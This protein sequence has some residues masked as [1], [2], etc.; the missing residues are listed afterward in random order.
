[1]SALHGTRLRYNVARRDMVC[2]VVYRKQSALSQAEARFPLKSKCRRPHSPPGITLTQTVETMDS[3]P[4]I[5]VN[6]GEALGQ[7]SGVTAW[8]LFIC[9]IFSDAS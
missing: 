9:S 5:T 4:P 2:P 1:M 8:E 3:L 7:W 6:K